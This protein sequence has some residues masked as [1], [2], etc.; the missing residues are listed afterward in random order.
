MDRIYTLDLLQIALSE[1][2][3]KFQRHV[4]FYKLYT[5]LLD[6]MIFYIMKGIEAFIFSEN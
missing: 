3:N 5:F 2:L 6:A 4:L 1:G